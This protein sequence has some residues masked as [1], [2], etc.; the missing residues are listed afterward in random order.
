MTTPLSGSPDVA[1]VKLAGARE[2]LGRHPIPDPDRV[3]EALDMIPL[4]VA[5]LEAAY[6]EIDLLRVACARRIGQ[7]DD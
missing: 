2:H 4:L 7:N 3:H 1:R 6:R 5:R